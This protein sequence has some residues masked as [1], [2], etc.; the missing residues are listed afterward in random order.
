MSLKDLCYEVLI[1]KIDKL[2]DIRLYFSETNTSKVE[3]NS[4]DTKR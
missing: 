2:V 4:I 3:L 1:E